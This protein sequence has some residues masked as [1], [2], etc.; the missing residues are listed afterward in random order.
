MHSIVNNMTQPQTIGEV[1]L[2]SGGQIEVESVDKR[3]RG[4]EKRGFVSINKIETETAPTANGAKTEMTVNNK[5][6]K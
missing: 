2:P 5:E 3:T 6:K 4:L 1:T